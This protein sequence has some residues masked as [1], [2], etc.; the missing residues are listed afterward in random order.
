MMENVSLDIAEQV[1]LNEVKFLNF[2][3]K[4]ARE[5]NQ[6]LKEQLGNTY[7]KVIGLG[8]PYEELIYY[9]RQVKNE[10]DSYLKIIREQQI[11][12]KKQQL[13]TL[14]KQRRRNFD[15]NKSY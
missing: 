5:R 12:E 3:L 1:V 9:A 8:T 15:S 4:E 2:V 7:A 14:K 10:L 13:N 6:S 11:D